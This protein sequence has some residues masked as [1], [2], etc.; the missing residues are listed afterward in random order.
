MRTP[1]SFLCVVLN[2][3]IDNTKLENNTL[4]NSDERLDSNSTYQDNDNERS[5]LFSVDT[6]YGQISEIDPINGAT[7]P[8]VSI[9][10]D[11]QISSMAFNESGIAYVYDHIN[12]KIGI[13]DPCF[14]DL[15]LLPI[16]ND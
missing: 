2:G 16:A 10:M 8:I 5:V 13:F 3:C 4:L 6:T 12:R 14:G 1:L 7:T 15:N 9:S 11:H